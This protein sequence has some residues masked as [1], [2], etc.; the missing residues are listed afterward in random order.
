MV[1]NNN[2]F[3]LFYYQIIWLEITIQD[4]IRV[5]KGLYTSGA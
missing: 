1:R 4:I 5:P 2:I 3:K